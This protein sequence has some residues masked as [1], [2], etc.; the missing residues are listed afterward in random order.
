[1]YDWTELVAHQI[2]IDV[3]EPSFCARDPAPRCH[4]K[5][6]RYLVCQ[7]EVENFPH[8]NVDVQ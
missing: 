3:F 4:K 2:C 1:M 5:N 7:K 6:Q 8:N